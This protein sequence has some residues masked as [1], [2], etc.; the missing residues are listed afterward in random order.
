MEPPRKSEF[1]VLCK[2][3]REAA[4]P[5]KLK[6]REVAAAIG[7]KTSTYG[8]VETSP[9]KVLGRD[10]VERLAELFGLEGAERAAFIAVWERCPLSPWGLRRRAH[11]ERQRA[12]RSISRHYP[13]L[14]LALIETL[15]LLLGVAQGRSLCTCLF[16]GGTV[17]DTRRNCEFCEA[18]EA[19][20]IPPNLD[21]TRLYERL[22]M[23]AEE[24][25]SKLNLQRGSHDGTQT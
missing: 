4:S 21:E 10:R 15:S 17:Y 25:E 5:R 16:G 3:L 8:N 14:K 18:V 12:R 13:R 11:F 1:A 2:T 24:L 22:A 7:I 20:G 6:H 19:L 9:Y 23:L